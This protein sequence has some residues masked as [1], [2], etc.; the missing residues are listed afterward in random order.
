MSDF[1][2]NL[3]A[4]ISNDSEIA[5]SYLRK[6]NPTD[7]DKLNSYT[8]EIKRRIIFED[9]E[10]LHSKFQRKKGIFFKECLKIEN[11]VKELIARVRESHFQTSFRNLTKINEQDAEK[12]LQYY[13]LLSSFDSEEFSEKK[14][15]ATSPSSYSEQVLS[16]YSITNPQD[17]N[18]DGII[19][20][21]GIFLDEDEMSSSEGRLL[22][23]NN[24]AIISVNAG[25]EENGKKRF[26][27]AHE[28]GHFLLHKNKRNY[29]L[30]TSKDFNDWFTRSNIEAQAN[31][32]AANLLMPEQPFK[33]AF[34]DA[35][36]LNEVLKVKDKF[37][38]TFTSTI[39]RYIDVGSKPIGMF[40]F[41]KEGKRN[42][43]Y[44]CSDNF[45]YKCYDFNTPPK[46]SLS[47]KALRF[48]N[49][50]S[51]DTIVEQSAKNW[52]PYNLEGYPKK[53][54]FEQCLQMPKYDTVLTIIWT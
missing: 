36:N 23:N 35:F 1:L 2:K 42:P 24:K 10:A 31:Q 12:I 25:I 44:Y 48:N 3:T 49:D 6:T 29:F 21:M 18:L 26:I 5:E 27:Q 33:E 40:L 53:L 51:L 30:C 37:D 45:P 15:E 46:N 39:R 28:L 14:Y 4:A 50:I 9:A 19:G 11:S 7:L 22:I 38:T 47:E 8:S 41:K 32:F 13:D 34:K 17:I 54:I 52:F 43:W 20:D 16:Y